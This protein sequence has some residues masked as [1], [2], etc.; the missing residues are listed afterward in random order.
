[1]ENSRKVIAA[2]ALRTR[3]ERKEKPYEDYLSNHANTSQHNEKTVKART[4][5]SNSLRSY[6]SRSVFTGLSTL[7][8]DSHSTSLS[9]EQSVHL[10]IEFL[11]QF[12]AE[13]F[14]ELIKNDMVNLS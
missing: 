3:T 9:K 14:E 12:Y 7:T 5:T 2:K 4:R 8:K 11:L 1:M 13:D 6:S 10:S